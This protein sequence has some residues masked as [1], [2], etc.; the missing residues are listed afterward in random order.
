MGC[1]K[2]TNAAK[3][4]SPWW[5]TVDCTTETNA[6]VG[7]PGWRTVDCTTETNAALGPP[8]GGLWQRVATRDWMLQWVSLVEGPLHYTTVL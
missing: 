1:T 6:A 5:R 2:D 4:G 3:S 8:G 7:P